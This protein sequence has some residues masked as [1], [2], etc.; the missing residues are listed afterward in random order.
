MIKDKFK[1]LPARA[2]SAVIVMPLVLLAVWA[3]GIYYNVLIGTA[4]VLGMYE[5][6][7]LHERSPSIL[8]DFFSYGTLVLIWWLS[9]YGLYGFACLTITAITG[10]AYNFYNRVKLD[11]VEWLAL[12][13]P[14]L[15]TPMVALMAVGNDPMSREHYLIFFLLAVVWATDI[16]AYLFGR[17]IGGPKLA[18]VISP[19]KTWSGALGATLFGTLV[20]L[21][22]ARYFWQ[23]SYTE[24]IILGV[25]L[26]IFT[27][28][29]DMF[30]SYVK[31][32]TGTK[33]SGRILPGH[34]GILDRID[35]LLF[36]AVMIG[37][38]QFAAPAWLQIG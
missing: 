7:R 15:G 6:L 22:F 1:D 12:G 28:L 13:I 31:R 27:Q 35:G 3:G 11:N 30:E 33:D 21:I 24:V 25:L 20:G 23:H 5:W 34:G 32:I 17:V 37:G 16:G 19:S 9:S 38:W 8:C 4:C 18:P 10:V 2:L 26:T 14:Y 36:A 29:G